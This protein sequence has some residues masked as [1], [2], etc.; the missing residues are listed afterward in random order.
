M[1]FDGD[2]AAETR[3]ASSQ[4][5]DEDKIRKILKINEGLFMTTMV[6]IMLHILKGEEEQDQ[7]EINAFIRLQ[8]EL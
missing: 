1:N 6:Y 2:V 7:S 8:T 5:I 4:E 3:E